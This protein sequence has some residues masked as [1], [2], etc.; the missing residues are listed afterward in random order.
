MLIYAD[1]HGGRYPND[2][3]ELLATEDLS[4]DTLVCGSTNDSPTTVPATQ[5]TSADLLQGGHCSYVYLGKGLS[6]ATV[7]AAQ[8]IAYEPLGHHGDATNFLYGDGHVDF[9]R[10]AQGQEDHRRAGGGAESAAGG[11]G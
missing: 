8:V 6:P 2:L 10:G 9:V 5:V 3:A 4:P 11:E 7:P 1:G